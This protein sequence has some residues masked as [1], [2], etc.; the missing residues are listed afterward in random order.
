M[1]ELEPG[2]IEDLLQELAEADSTQESPPQAAKELLRDLQADSIDARKAAVERL[3]RLD[4]SSPEI[5]RALVVAKET[6]SIYAIRKA[7]EEALRAAVHQEHFQQATVVPITIPGH[8]QVETRGRTLHITWKPD[9]LQRVRAA[10]IPLL[11]L[12][13]LILALMSGRSPFLCLLSF[14][15]LFISGYW[16]LAV[17]V[18][19]MTLMAGPEE[20]IILRGP[21]PLPTRHL[22]L[23]TR[24]LDPTAFTRVWYDRVGKK[25]GWSGSGGCA[26]YILRLALGWETSARGGKELIASYMLL[27]RCGGGSDKKLLTGLSWEEARYLKKMLQNLLELEGGSQVGD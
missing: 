10:Y 16:L 24:R 2:E 27:A 8:F 5:V 25:R 9:L 18:N 22:V 3:G 1:E 19:S 12:S 17:F 26:E 20:W 21:L 6:D 14:A 11:L 15:V 23:R 13:L 4:A 7:A